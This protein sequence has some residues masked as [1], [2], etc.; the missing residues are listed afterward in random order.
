[1]SKSV[2]VSNGISKQ[3]G[4]LGRSMP[5]YPKRE[6]SDGLASTVETVIARIIQANSDR[7]KN[8]MVASSRLSDALAKGHDLP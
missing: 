5:E 1:M 2:L 7:Q 3:T 4:F 8:G 6:H